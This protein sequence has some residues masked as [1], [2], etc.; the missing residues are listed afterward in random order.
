ML[1]FVNII[2]LL[3]NLV[4]GSLENPFSFVITVLLPL[5][6]VGCLVALLASRRWG[7]YAFAGIGVFAFLFNLAAGTGLVQAF[8]GFLAVPMLYVVLNLGS[9]SGWQLLR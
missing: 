7:F 1:L 4:W 6:N 9:R 3:A 8:V 2:V 5:L